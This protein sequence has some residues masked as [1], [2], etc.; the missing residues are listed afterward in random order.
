MLYED[1]IPVSEG[2]NT[3]TYVIFVFSCVFG[4][5]GG[6]LSIYDILKIK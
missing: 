6:P 5:G 4:R 3:H 1:R 2:I